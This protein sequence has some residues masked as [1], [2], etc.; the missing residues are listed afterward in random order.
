MPEQFAYQFSRPEDAV[1]AQWLERFGC[2]AP[3]IHLQQT[4][5][6]SSS[7]QS[8]TKQTLAT[9]LIHGP[10][11]LRALDR[12]AHQAPPP[13][14]PPKVD[15]VY[16]TLE[17]FLPTACNS[18]AVLEDIAESVQYWRRYVPVDN[19]ELSEAVAALP[20]SAGEPS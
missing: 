13:G 19:M 3:I 16:L 7:H 18:R 5:G 2:Y 10:D 9:G 11:V 8:F 6:A 15:H 14:Y 20:L 17:P 12:S 1:P 4:D